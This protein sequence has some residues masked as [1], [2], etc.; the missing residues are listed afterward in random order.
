M[1]KTKTAKLSALILLSVLAV[2]FAAYAVLKY[3]TVVTNTAFIKGF[4]AA[5][6]RIDTGTAVTSIAWGGIDLGTTVDT[7]TLFGITKQLAI[8][9]T[10][11]YQIYAGWNL[12]GTLPSGVTLVCA[13]WISGTTWNNLPQNTFPNEMH[14]TANGVST[15]IRFTLYAPANAPK[16]TLNFNI[17]LLASDEIG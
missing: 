11:D 6:W 5:L 10:G 13:R 7:E 2:S 16:S 4:E 12:T 14:V 17:T 1:M 15:P 9:N 3:S 8:K